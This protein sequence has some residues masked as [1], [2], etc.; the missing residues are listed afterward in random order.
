MWGAKIVWYYSAGMISAWGI[1]ALPGLSITLMMGG[2]DIWPWGEGL[3][4]YFIDIC[5]SQFPA[6]LLTQMCRIPL[7]SG[8]H[9][10]ALWPLITA[11]GWE[12]KW[13]GVAQCYWLW[14]LGISF[15]SWTPSY[16][17][18]HVKRIIRP[19][20][21]IS[22]NWLWVSCKTCSCPQSIWK[23]WHMVLNA[24]FLTTFTFMLTII[25]C[26]L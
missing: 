4:R 11:P 22:C 12:I 10:R 15:L 6:W 1:I 23:Y 25:R 5:V 18:T 3:L 13:L 17:L 14:G 19:F 7:A 24:L 2:C 9:Y 21:V 16:G 20:H 8:A 26:V